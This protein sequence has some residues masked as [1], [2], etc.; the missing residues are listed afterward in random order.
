MELNNNRPI[1]VLVPYS[2]IYEKLMVS[3]LLS[4]FYRNF[5]CCKTINLASGLAEAL[6]DAVLRFV[7]FIYNSFNEKKHTVSILIDLRKAFDTVP[8]SILLQK[9]EKYGV[10][11]TPLQW[12]HSYFNN[13]FQRVK[14]NKHLSDKGDVTC[15]VIQGSHL[16]PIAFLLYYI[17]DL[18]NVSDLFHAILYADDTVLSV[19]GSNLESIISDTNDHLNI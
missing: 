7:E 11:G 16:G 6:C 9:F 19:S 13:R 4:F 15:G 5:H 2:K 12:F 18:P 8:H 17:N 14:I 3:R 1:S 10:R